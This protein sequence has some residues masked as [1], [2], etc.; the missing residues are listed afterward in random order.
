MSTKQNTAINPTQDTPLIQLTRTR[1]PRIKDVEV[2]A[3]NRASIAAGYSNPAT[4]MVHIP[5]TKNAFGRTVRYH[6]ALHVQHTPARTKMADALDQALE[7]ARLHRYKSLA[8]TTQFP[9]ARRDEISVALR[10][11]RTVA[12][13][14]TVSAL[15][16]IVTLRAMAILLADL[17]GM[18]H[19][20]LLARVVNKF[21]P[22]A[23]DDFQRAI[24]MLESSDGKRDETWERARKH[25]ERYFAKDY[26]PPKH[27]SGKGDSPKDAEDGE[28]EESE[29]SDASRESDSESKNTKP[30]KDMDTGESDSSD[31]KPSHESSK[32]SDAGEE[33]EEG[34]EESDSDSDS[35][36]SEETESTEEDEK[37]VPSPK[38]EEKPVEVIPAEPKPRTRKRA[39]KE[40]EY[41]DSLVA[42]FDADNPLIEASAREWPITVY[43]RRLDMGTNRVKLSLG[44]R[45]EAPTKRGRKIRGSRLAAAS[46]QP[47]V[48]VFE[49]PIQAGQGGTILVDASASMGLTEEA[50]NAFLRDAPA[51]TLAFYNA[52]TD[53]SHYGNIYIYAANGFRASGFNR[54]ELSCGYI[55]GKSLSHASYGHGNVI[56]YQAMVWLSKQP[57]PRY[58]LTDCAWTQWQEA[59]RNAAARFE[60]NKTF[61][62]VRPRIAYT[63]EGVGY[64]QKPIEVMLRM[65]D[66]QRRRRA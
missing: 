26:A 50:L 7:D 25:V 46:F 6:E 16:S 24:K 36:T 43:I 42:P 63:A 35:A 38:E 33:S 47:G 30:G 9:Q 66:K 21:G 18:K 10:D 23:S 31:D 3:N 44:K 65:L 29:S 55:N 22:H 58:L 40:D 17:D 27:E 15:Q 59:C 62:V 52:P 41:T 56:D 20:S 37:P 64:R 14:E 11:L 45:R 28:G 61:T 13:R 51:L 54:D 34:E 39:P 4:G 1:S 12:R 8:H 60:A 49:R 53:F 5:D 57:G 48:R 2:E 19:A 32:S